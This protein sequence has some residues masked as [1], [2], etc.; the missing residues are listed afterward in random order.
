MLREDVYL[1]Y[2]VEILKGDVNLFCI[3]KLVKCDL[4]VVIFINKGIKL[5]KSI[6]K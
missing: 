1:N 2:L 3:F 6:N 5:I 4:I